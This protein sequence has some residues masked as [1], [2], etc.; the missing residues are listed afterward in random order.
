M[1]LKIANSISI[2]KQKNTLKFKYFQDYS[3][4]CIMKCEISYRYV[5][6]GL[7]LIKEFKGIITLDDIIG[8][9]NEIIIEGKLVKNLKGVITDFRAGKEMLRFLNLLHYPASTKSM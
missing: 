1:I 6:D 7:V 2:H 8:S 3:D 9:W 5:E 4:I